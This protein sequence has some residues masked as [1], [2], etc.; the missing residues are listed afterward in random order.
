MKNLKAIDLKRMLVLFV[1]R[2]E[3]IVTDYSFTHSNILFW[4]HWKINHTNLC[5]NMALCRKFLLEI[6]HTQKS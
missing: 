6:L 5:F 3:N 2:F 1:T 4:Y